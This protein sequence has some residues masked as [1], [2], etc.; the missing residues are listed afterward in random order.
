MKTLFK[1]L[2]G[3]L[4]ALVLLLG[5]L[6]LTL[7]ARLPDS[8]FSVEPLSLD[9]VSEPSSVL[10]FGG[11]KNTGLMVAKLF[12][13]RGDEVT[14]FVRS[15]SD[16]SALEAIGAQ[17]VRGDALDIEAVRAAFAAGTFDSVITTMGCLN[18]V[19][20]SDY[21]ANANVFAVAAE[22]GV[23][24]VL[25]V[26]TIGAGD[27]AEFTPWVSRQAL[28]RTLPLK[29]Q[30]EEEL[31]ASELDF[32]IVRP[33]GLR[34]GF[35]TGQGVLSEDIQTFGFIFREDLARLI[36]AAVDDQAAIGKTF[37]AIDTSR[38]FQWDTGAVK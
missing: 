28:A 2:G 36:V 9:K 21:Q 5:G 35:E 14:A 31:R 10:I 20:P 38:R 30:A 32:T 16:A 13:Q 6:M 12:R 17:L 23:K 18:C 29:T 19:P 11:R 8:V 4:L 15:S 1:I 25:L 7:E 34:S 22:A 27:S 24:R 3:I 26:T 37:S 33:G